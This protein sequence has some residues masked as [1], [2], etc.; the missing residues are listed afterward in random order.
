MT[1]APLQPIRLD[2]PAANR[3]VLP[4]HLHK[5]GLCLARTLEAGKCYTVTI[6]TSNY[7]DGEPVWVIREEGKVENQR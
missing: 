6:F 2:E 7:A 5:L 4:K 1:T 3:G